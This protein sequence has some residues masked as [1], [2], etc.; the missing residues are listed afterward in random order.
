MQ[1][2]QKRH[3]NKQYWLTIG[4]AP[5]V[6][7][8]QRRM[9][10]GKGVDSRT[11]PF[12]LLFNKVASTVMQAH[13]IPIVDTYSIASALFDMSYDAGHYIGTV[14]LAQAAMVAN[15]FCNDVQQPPSR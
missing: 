1:A 11:D 13:G 4:P 12:L 9:N 3:G 15:I 10:V 14:G 5:L 8:H 2:Q 7:Y 6:D